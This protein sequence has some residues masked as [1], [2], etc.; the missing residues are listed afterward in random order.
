[1]ESCW[2]NSLLN[3]TNDDAELISTSS[4]IANYM[5]VHVNVHASSADSPCLQNKC[6]IWHILGQ[7][8]MKVILTPA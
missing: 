4:Q 5:Y 3:R 2:K 7:F 8:L 6:K 1:M